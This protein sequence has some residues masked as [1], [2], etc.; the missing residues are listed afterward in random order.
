MS[1]IILCKGEYASEGYFFPKTKTYVYS[2]EEVCFYIKS[3][4]YLI[5][6][7]YFGEEFVRWVEEELKITNL[8]QKLKKLLKD[9]ADIKDLVVTICCACDY[10]TQAEI[11]D[12]I[13]I[14][15]ETQSL[16]YYGRIKIKA[17]NYYKCNEL[18]KAEREY[19]HLLQHIDI[20]EDANEEMSAVYERLGLI[21]LKLGEY[22][23]SR[24]CYTKAYIRNRE[25]R[26]FCGFMT[27]LQLD[28]TVENKIDEIE[29][30]SASATDMKNFEE[31]WERITD[32]ARDS[33]LY[34]MV[35]GVKNS[36]REG[37]KEEVNARIKE[38]LSIIKDEYKS[39]NA[40]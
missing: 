38:C 35:N 11:E 25:F 32:L 1:K 15:K 18:T 21:A 40:V 12:L 6:E 23:K 34:G 20:S 4:I 39:M 3:N 24:E 33:K 28:V 8:A 13:G 30:L 16:D 10:Y 2:I 9:K 26:A 7:D 14:M 36:Y 22:K 17:A 27:A 29:K 37:A 19:N 5:R 31:L